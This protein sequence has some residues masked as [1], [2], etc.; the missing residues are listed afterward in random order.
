VASVETVSLG[1]GRGKGR[2]EEEDARQWE[3]RCE[4]S[5]RCLSGAVLGGGGLLLI[6]SRVRSARGY[7]GPRVWALTATPGRARPTTRRREIRDRECRQRCTHPKILS[8]VPECEATLEVQTGQGQKTQTGK[9]ASC[10]LGRSRAKMVGVYVAAPRID[11][12]GSFK[13]MRVAM[14]ESVVTSRGSRDKTD[15]PPLGNC[16]AH[17]TTSSF[18]APSR[19]ASYSRLWPEGRSC[20]HHSNSMATC[21]PTDAYYKLKDA[22]IQ[23]LS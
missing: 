3:Q 14:G 12:R 11:T 16:P 7:G 10:V 19:A 5:Q 6:T 17:S 21:S 9:R 4:A 2:E 18:T 23:N 1:T 22:Y 15:P 20:T 13:G 8:C